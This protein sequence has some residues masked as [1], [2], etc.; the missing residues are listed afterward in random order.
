MII[1]QTVRIDPSTFKLPLPLGS[2]KQKL[3]TCLICR[4][5]ALSV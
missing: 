3:L 5:E 1:I 2:T 4:S